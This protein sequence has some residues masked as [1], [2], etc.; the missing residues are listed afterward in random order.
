M[1]AAEPAGGSDWSSAYHANGATAAQDRKGD[2]NG[3]SASANVLFMPRGTEINLSCCEGFLTRLAFVL[4]PELP[5]PGWPIP[6]FEGIPL[7]AFW[8]D[9]IAEARA[10]L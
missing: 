5:R 7:V 8:V 4:T 10:F 3:Q 6:C 9:K 2:N 1:H